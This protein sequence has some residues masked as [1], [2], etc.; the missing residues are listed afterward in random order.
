MQN[1]ESLRLTSAR[2]TLRPLSA[3][4]A[5]ALF[6]IFSDAQV[7]RHLSHPAWSDI[8]QA[9]A[10]IADATACL[11]NASAIKLGIFVSATGELAGTIKL[12]HFE[13]GSR[14]CD[15]GYALGQSHWGVG[16]MGEALHT[17]IDFAFQTLELNRV[18]A[19]IDPVNTASAKTLLRLGFA[20]EGLLRERWIVA[21]RMSDTAMYGLLRR[22]WQ[23]RSTGA[24]AWSAQTTARP[25]RGPVRRIALGH[26]DML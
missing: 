23:A 16:Y 8:A 19:D 10:E 12:Y 2:L 9:E 26:A 17:L 3:T 7:A 1:Y 20:F 5:S 4:D 11:R 22:D 14:R 24:L 21:G 25:R 13:A 18:E 15:V 6:A